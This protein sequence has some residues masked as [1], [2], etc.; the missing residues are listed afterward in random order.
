M[1]RSLPCICVRAAAQLAQAAVPAPGD[2][3]LLRQLQEHVATLTTKLR[4]ATEETGET[5]PAAEVAALQAQLDDLRGQLAHEAK[6]TAALAAVRPQGGRAHGDECKAF[7]DG[8]LTRDDP[9]A[10]FGGGRR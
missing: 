2:P 10:R 4:A 6:R 5:V 1:T 8:R 7:L 9:G 3:T